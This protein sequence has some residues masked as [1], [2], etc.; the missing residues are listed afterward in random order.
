VLRCGGCGAMWR[1]E[2][3]DRIEELTMC[4]RA[5]GDRRERDGNAQFWHGIADRLLAAQTV[6]V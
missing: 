2:E 4:L 5:E 6:T 3:R 1:E